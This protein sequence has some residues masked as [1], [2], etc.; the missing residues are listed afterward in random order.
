MGETGGPV[1]AL[2]AAGA[3]LPLAFDH[4][5]MLATA[6]LRLR[7]KLGYTPVG[8]ALLPDRFTLRQLQDVHE[9]ILGRP[10]NKDS[11]RRSMLASGKLEPTHERE[12]GVGHRPAVLYRRRLPAP[13]PAGSP[14]R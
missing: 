14:R 11:F 9:T 4:A 13:A 10:L 8:Y 3:R 6:V 1:H 5:D 7:G 2:D 12:E